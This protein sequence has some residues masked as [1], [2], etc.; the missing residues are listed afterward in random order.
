MTSF[1]NIN[2]KP[3][4]LFIPRL[5]PN[6]T[7]GFISEYF[8]ENKIGVITDIKDKHRVN[9]NKNKYWFAF[10]TV[11]F[12]D[13]PNGREMYERILEKEETV[14]MTY[15]KSEGKYW[16][17]SIRSQDR[18]LYKKTVQV[19]KAQ[20]KEV[21]ITVTPPPTPTREVLEEGEIDETNFTYYDHVDIYR[22]YLELEKEIFG[23]NYR[24]PTISEEELS[25]W[26]R[27][28]PLRI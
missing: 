15:N 18:G 17:I 4:I 2:S 7:K 8:K 24:E 26:G 25:Q 19:V 5:L 23:N 16:E 28:I 3:V 1:N 13:T 12:V 27:F 14:Y 22:D 9:E 21:A 11:Y 20:E 6:I 10:L